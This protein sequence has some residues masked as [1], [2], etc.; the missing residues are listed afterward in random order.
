MKEIE[1][2]REGVSEGNWK[3]FKVKFMFASGN[4]VYVYATC[5]INIL[6]RKR[7]ANVNEK[8]SVQSNQ[9]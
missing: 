3:A 2:R 6:Q 4:V 8:C 1:S 5:P 7:D 9:G